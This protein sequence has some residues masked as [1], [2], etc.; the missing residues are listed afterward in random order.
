MPDYPYMNERE[1]ATQMRKGY[2]QS[3]KISPVR[4]PRVS[5][6]T[7]KDDEL[8]KV[9]RAGIVYDNLDNQIIEALA[10]DTEYWTYEQRVAVRNLIEAEAAR[11]EQILLD[12]LIDT[13]A[14][15]D[16][17]EFYDDDN[18]K[19][20]DAHTWVARRRTKHNG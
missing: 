9:T 14:Y 7:N 1:K 16:S 10:D 15:P 3:R 4:Q 18:N 13:L 2:M 20:I 19:L 5:D 6:T 8:R 17:V 11:R 12:E